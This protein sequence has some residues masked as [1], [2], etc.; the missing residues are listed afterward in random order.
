M[1][2]M[3]ASAYH[4]ILGMLGKSGIIYHAFSQPKKKLTNALD[5]LTAIR[6]SCNPGFL[7]C[8]PVPDFSQ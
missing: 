5:K 7:K 8:L 6:L 4:M 2:I 3:F 1:N